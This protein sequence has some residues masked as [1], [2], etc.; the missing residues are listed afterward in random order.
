[1]Y[2]TQLWRLK[3]KSQIYMCEEGVEI[4]QPKLEQE[5]KGIQKYGFEIKKKK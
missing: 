2:L 4:N 1:M 3:T 5:T